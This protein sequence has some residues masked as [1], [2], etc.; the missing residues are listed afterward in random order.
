MKLLALN[1]VF[2]RSNFAPLH[3]RNFLYEEVKLEYR[4]QNTRIRPFKLQHPR[5]TVAP[6]GVCKYMVS[7]VSQCW[8]SCIGRGTQY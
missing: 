4:L 3:S 2:T 6:S 1:V 5:E 7:N 8:N